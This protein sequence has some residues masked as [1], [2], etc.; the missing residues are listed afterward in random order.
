MEK[1]IGCALVLAGCTGFAGSLCRERQER[2]RMLKQI[3]GIYEDL[4]YYISYQ[5][6]TVLEA[7]LKIAGKGEEPFAGAFREIYRRVWEE[8]EN[9]LLV[10]QQQM[11]SGLG[12]TPLSPREKKLVYDFSACLG[13]MEENAQA[14]ALDEL[15]REAASC[16]EELERERKNKNKMTMSLGIAAGVLISILLL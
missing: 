4:K 6:A 12:A 13:Y 16:I 11:E 3:R 9:L 7:L 8:G 5:R 10:W 1:L 15:L 2:V 14:G